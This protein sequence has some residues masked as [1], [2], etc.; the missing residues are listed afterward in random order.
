[1]IKKIIFSTLLVLCMIVLIIYFD[2]FQLYTKTILRLTGNFSSPEYETNASIMSKVQNE[3]IYY[4]RLYKLTDYKAFMDF[5][6]KKI[7]T[8]PFVQIYDQNKKMIKIANG[9][10]CSWALMDFF[11]KSDS[12]N[13]TKGDSLM[14]KFVM[15]RLEPIDL[16]TNQDTFDYY[17]LAGWANYIP[18][19]SDSLFNQTNKMKKTLIE[20][21]CFTYINLDFQ[22]EWAA[23]MDSVQR[24]NKKR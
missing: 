22:K 19:L 3:K 24:S 14:Y 9:S 2:P 13:L 15:D 17:I 12:L 1:M 4:D 21:V 6:K 18:R 7:T 5:T 20:K 8:F 23:E 11:S 10:D 16:K